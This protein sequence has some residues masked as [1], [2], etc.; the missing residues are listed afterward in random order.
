M[1]LQGADQML[2]ALPD[3]Q[4]FVLRRVPA[5][6]DLI[7]P[8]DADLSAGSFHDAGVPDALHRNTPRRGDAVRRSEITPPPCHV[9]RTR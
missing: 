8:E 7:A 9:A 5:R 4:V 6:L 1:M 2:A 3:G